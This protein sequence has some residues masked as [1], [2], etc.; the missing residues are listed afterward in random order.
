MAESLFEHQRRDQLARRIRERTSIDTTW[1]SDRHGLLV[2]R[3][4]SGEF[5]VHVPPSISR[6]GP[7]SIVTPVAE[8]GSDLRRGERVPNRKALTRPGATVNHDS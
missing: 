8:D 6:E 7:C 2:Q 4:P 1:D 5:Q 3:L